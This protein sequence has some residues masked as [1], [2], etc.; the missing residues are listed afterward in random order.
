M[1]RRE[2]AL[3][4]T[5]VT[6]TAIVLGVM[7]TLALAG[8]PGQRPPAATPWD[9]SP[10]GS[11]MG[12]MGWGTRGLSGNSEFDYLTEMVA[13]HQDAV[14]AARQLE[15]SGRAEMRALG[16]SIVTTQTAEITQM[17]AWL[18][19]WYPGRSTAVSYQPM[20]RDLSRLSG[21]TL[22]EAFLRDMIPHHMAAVMMSQQ[23]LVQGRIQHPELTEFAARVRDSQHAEIF[24]MQ[25]YLADWFDGTWRM[26]YGHGGGGRGPG[27]MMGW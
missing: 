11:G 3:L 1:V 23:L 4:F 2:K 27:G 19:Q 17:N 9:A 21:D 14:N 12:P 13:H 8:W 26:P 6:I 7:S 18:A 24:Q 16:A 20:M 22:D 10:M 25:R 15:R 5:A